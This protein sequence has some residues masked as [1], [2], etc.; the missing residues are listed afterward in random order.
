MSLL[1]FLI[2]FLYPLPGFLISV[3]ELQ[4]LSLLWFFLGGC[5]CWNSSREVLE[6]FWVVFLVSTKIGTVSLV[7]STVIWCDINLNNKALKVH[8]ELLNMCKKE[9]FDYKDHKNMQPRT[10]LNKSRLLL[11][12][13]SSVVMGK[14][15]VN[16]FQN[17]IPHLIPIF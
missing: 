2:L 6:F 11:N 10:H 5:F 1:H 17:I 7:I 14:N 9:Q 13:N 8:Q 12:Q 16:F 15:F 4:F 3:L